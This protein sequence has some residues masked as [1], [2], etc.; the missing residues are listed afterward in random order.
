MSPQLTLAHG[1]T[2]A[3][4]YSVDGAARIDARFVDAS[5]GRR[6]GACRAPRGRTRV[7]RDALDRKEESELL[8]ARRAALEDF[9]ARCSA[10]SRGARAQARHHELAPLFAVKRQFVQRKAMNAYKADA[11]R[12]STAPRCAPSSKPRSACAVLGELGFAQAVTR[13]QAD[14]AAHAAELDLALRY[15]AWAAHTPAGRTAHRGG[16]LFRAPRKL[17]YMK[18]VPVE[19]ETRT[20]CR[21]GS[22]TRDHALRRREGFALTDPGTDLAGALDQAHYCIWCH[23]QG[24]DSC[25]QGL[26]EKK[27]APAARCRS[28]RA[29]SA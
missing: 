15:A 7:A 12:R 9:V 8:I 19:A 27:P 1:L 21:R 17:D 29:R 22:S 18:L 2:F 26:L 16:V 11:A 4:L 6:C 5:R 10:S 23:E 14:E 13:W 24:K 28:R 20:A 25:S 3:D